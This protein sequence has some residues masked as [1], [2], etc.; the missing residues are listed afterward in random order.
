MARVKTRRVVDTR[1]AE[2]V[3]DVSSGK[4]F[5]HVPFILGRAPSVHQPCTRRAVRG[6]KDSIEVRDSGSRLRFK[7]RLSSQ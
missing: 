3:P 1:L 7:T 6:A 5:I 2:L 4:R